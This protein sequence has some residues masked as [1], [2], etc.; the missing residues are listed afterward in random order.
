[1]SDVRIRQ[2]LDNAE[3]LRILCDPPG[4]KDR[5][6]VKIYRSVY[7]VGEQLVSAVLWVKAGQAPVVQL[8]KRFGETITS[9]QTLTHPLIRAEDHAVFLGLD[10]CEPRTPV[11]KQDK[12]VGAD[13]IIVSDA[14]GFMRNANGH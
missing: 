5:I 9:S 1:M 3:T 6:N 13:L 4:D 8:T 10:Q 12:S 14:A 7:M 11:W 2:L